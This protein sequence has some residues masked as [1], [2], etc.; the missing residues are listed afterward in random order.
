[1]NLILS[2][3]VSYLFLLKC[4]THASCPNLCN[5]NGVCDKFS[6]FS[7][8]LSSQQFN[9]MSI[10]TDAL[11]LADFKEQTVLREFVR[12]A[13]LGLTRL[14]IPIPLTPLQSVQIGEYVIVAVVSF[15]LRYIWSIH[16]LILT[17]GK[18]ECMEGF[19]GSSC[20][21]LNCANDCNGKGIC[22]SMKDF[23]SRTRWKF[24]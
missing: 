24:E 21:R 20:E 10:E 8:N 23:A 9:L 16:G 1:M 3:L 14:L 4:I 15:S 5:S 12:L 13:L 17:T 6:R 11:V 19:T 22:F 2:I 7:Y 18:C